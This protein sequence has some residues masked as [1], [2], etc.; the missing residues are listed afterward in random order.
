MPIFSDAEREH[1]RAALIDT[2]KQLFVQQGLKKTSLEELTNAVSIAKS[3]FYSFFESKEELY[4]ELLA[5]ERPTAEAALLPLLNIK[6][7]AADG[8]AEFLRTAVDYIDSTPITRRLITH[9]EEMQMVM[10][11]VTPEHLAS[12]FQYGILPIVQAIARW[13]QM[14]LVIDENPHVIAGVIRAVT[15]LILHKDDIGT[16]IYPQVLDLMIR[17]IAEGLA[18]KDYHQPSVG[19]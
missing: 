9:P 5:L 7:D 15:M 14:S 4:L 6:G 19:Q 18:R 12:K 10:R 1:I 8:I 17:L 11:R 16:Q 2:A 13:Q 3:S